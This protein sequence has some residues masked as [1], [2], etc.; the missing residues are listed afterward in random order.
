MSG[1]I[2]RW[3]WRGEYLA[4]NG[5]YRLA[6]S[7]PWR[8]LPV[9]GRR[10]GL[11]VHGAAPIRK[12]VVLANLRSVFGDERSEAEI[13]SLAREFYANMGITVL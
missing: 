7:L 13:A 6:Q 11:L 10:L 2:K 12:A 4:L 9:W 1:V 5:V 8:V 3:R